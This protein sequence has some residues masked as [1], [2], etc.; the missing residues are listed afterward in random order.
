MDLLRSYVKAV[1]R[2]LPREHRDAIVAERSEDLRSQI[3]AGRPTSIVR[4]ETRAIAHRFS[5][6]RPRDC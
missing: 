1:R 4:S 3:E 2:Y 5:A 6:G